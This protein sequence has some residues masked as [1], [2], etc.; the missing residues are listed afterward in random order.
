MDYIVLDM[1]WNQP[2]HERQIVKKPVKLYGEIVQIGAVKLDNDFNVTDTFK[3]MVTPKYYTRM[4][5]LVSRLTKITTENLQYGEPFPT[6]FENFKKWCGDCFVILTWG[7]DDIRIL[8][9]NLLLHGFDT[10]WIPDS[11]DVQLIFDAQVTKEKR[12]VSLSS[13]MEMLNE[14]AL[15]AHDALNDAKNT[16]CI[17]LR[18]DM[19]NGIAEYSNIK[20]ALKKRKEK[21]T[22]AVKT[23]K[24]RRSA[25]SDTELT[26]FFCPVCGELAVCKGFVRQN[27]D[28]YICC[29]RCENEHEFFV[30]FRFSKCANG[31]FKV[32]RLI[33]EMNDDNLGYYRS[34]KTRQSNF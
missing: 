7:P 16:A 11:Y 30:R 15:E 4:N 5:K 27:T 31:R 24:M 14:P 20:K 33:Y 9:D 22:P 1:E 29:A 8:H 28:K 21:K 6:A 2:S 18:L 19:K 12:Q 3:T 25:L 34:K 26:R 32:S 10:S 23:Y 13:A 17:C